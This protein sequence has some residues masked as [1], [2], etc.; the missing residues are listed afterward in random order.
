VEEP[1][2]QKLQKKKKKKRPYKSFQNGVKYKD[3]K[4]GDGQEV[5]KGDKVTVYYV[6]Q[7]SDNDTFDKVLSGKG[8]TYKYGAGEVIKGWDTGLE[9]MKAG[10]KR[11][12]IIPSELGYGESG[13]PPKIPPNADLHFTILVKKVA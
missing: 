7:T 2:P 5:S 6:G 10:G 13:S 1:S 12:L 9:G 4:F 11:K 3:I 8:F